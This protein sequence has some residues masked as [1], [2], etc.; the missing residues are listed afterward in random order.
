MEER[1]PK[2]K[3]EARDKAIEWQ[4]WQ[5]EQSLSYVESAK[6]QCYFEETGKKFGLLEEFK[7]NGIL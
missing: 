7:E 1:Q 5:A 3:E 4:Y 2:T 6:W